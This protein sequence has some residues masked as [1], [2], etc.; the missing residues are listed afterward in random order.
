MKVRR[1]THND[2][3]ERW[4]KVFVKSILSTNPRATQIEKLNNSRV[5]TVR[6]TATAYRE[7]VLV[8]KRAS[9][10]FFGVKKN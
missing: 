3:E 6:V 8:H 7:N 4:K 9:V 1:R 2:E 10:C 5:G